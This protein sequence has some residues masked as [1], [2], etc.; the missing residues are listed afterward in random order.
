[1]EDDRIT[2]LEGIAHTSLE[3][4]RTAARVA[5]GQQQQIEALLRI[6]KHLAAAMGHQPDAEPAAQALREIQE[7]ERM[8]GGGA[9]PEAL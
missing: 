5:A 7:L 4:H 6:A 3:A 9:S 2:A 8:F 1:M